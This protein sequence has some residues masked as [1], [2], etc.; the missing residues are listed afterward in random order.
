MPPNTFGNICQGLGKAG[1]NTMQ[2]RIIIE[3]PVGS[4]FKT[5]QDINNQVAKYFQESQ[6]FR[7]DHYL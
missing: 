7:I 6:I 2:A 3:K 1:L 4:S 5:S